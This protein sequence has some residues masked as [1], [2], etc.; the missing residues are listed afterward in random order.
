MSQYRLLCLHK[1]DN[2]AVALTEIP[3]QTNVE[4]QVGTEV[5]SLTVLENI[6]FGHKLAIKPIKQG[7]DVIKYGQVIGIATQEIK[8]GQHVHVHNIK[9]K[10]RE[11][12]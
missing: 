10:Q 8:P 7:E 5:V 11:E 2:V 12:V 1:E 4:L 9:S 3:A 6:R